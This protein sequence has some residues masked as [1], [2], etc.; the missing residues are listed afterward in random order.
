MMKKKAQ[1]AKSSSKQEKKW[2]QK[3]NLIC[4]TVANGF[5]SAH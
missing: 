1:M 3:H 4:T 5:R 2:A